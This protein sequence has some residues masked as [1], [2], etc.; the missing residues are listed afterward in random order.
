MV[1]ALLQVIAAVTVVML[2][3]FASIQLVSDSTALIPKCAMLTEFVH[4]LTIA[5]VILDIL[6][7][8]VKMPFALE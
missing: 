6:E 5:R 7:L 1:R 4:H 3:L 2:E 8:N